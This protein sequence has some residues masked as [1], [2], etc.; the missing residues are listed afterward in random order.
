MDK[1]TPS[2]ARNQTVAKLSA[3]FAQQNPDRPC[4]P[5]I[6]W[7][8]RQIGRSERQTS[9]GIAH[10]YAAGL[11]DKERR[12]RPN[13]SQTSN[14]WHWLGARHVTPLP[15]RTR[16]TFWKRGS[17]IRNPVAAYAAAYKKSHGRYPPRY[18]RNLAGRHVL[19]ARDR[20]ASADAIR[21]RAS[22]I[23]RTGGDLRLFGTLSGAPERLRGVPM[24]ADVAAVKDA[25]VPRRRRRPR[26]ARRVKAA[27]IDGFLNAGEAL[28]AWIERIR[29]C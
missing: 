17:K 12:T 15:T 1:S 19:A 5:S 8:A 2:A 26:P 14:M 7:L 23:G 28:T 25:L 6:R 20:R 29:P 21:L 16:T 11:L 27:H 3:W 10:L 4:Y 22:H 9:R 24:P 13:G 18:C